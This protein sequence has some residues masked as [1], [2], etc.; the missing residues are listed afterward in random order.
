M[1]KRRMWEIIDGVGGSKYQLVFL[2]SYD[3]VVN[4][5]ARHQAE[6]NISDLSTYQQPP[7]LI[8]TKMELELFIRNFP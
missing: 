4:L 7:R 6:T 2:L 5:A 8:G 1:V 3:K